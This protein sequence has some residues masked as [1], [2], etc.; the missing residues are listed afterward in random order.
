MKIS[1]AIAQLQA[2]HEQHGDADVA[3]SYSIRT[4][5]GPAGLSGAQE[6][7]KLHEDRMAICFGCDRHE[8]VKVPLTTMEFVRCLE[9]GCAIFAKARIPSA[10]CPIG[11]W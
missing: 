2:L 5:D 1:E 10:K 7:T 4:T 8:I 3:F 9:C 11:K 6:R